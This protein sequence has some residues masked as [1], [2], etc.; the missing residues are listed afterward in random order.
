MGLDDCVELLAKVPALTG[1]TSEQLAVIAFTAERRA[2]ETGQALIESGGA[3][4][5]AMILLAGQADETDAE[6]NSLGG[7]I[8]AGTMINEIGMLID[9]HYPSSIMARTPV[10]VLR[11]DRVFMT[12]LLDRYPD[13]K[14][15]VRNR[16][17]F[18]LRRIQSRLVKI[19]E[20]MRAL[21][22]PLT[23]DAP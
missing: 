8:G 17:E 11:L 19:D 4:E 14:G 15:R 7:P 18:R 9:N 1:C 16:L 6:G 22:A 23:T 21:D 2:F 3:A 20:L 12:R 10:Q 5:G 13:F